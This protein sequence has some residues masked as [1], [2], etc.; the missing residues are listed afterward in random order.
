MA[1]E[2]EEMLRRV[3]FSKGSD[4]KARLRKML[5]AETDEIDLDDMEMVYAAVK[6]P[7]IPIPRNHENRN[8]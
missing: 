8:G 4:H 5:F 7:D 2:M 3:D 1:D 6:D